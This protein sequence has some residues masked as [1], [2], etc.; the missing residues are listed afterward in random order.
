MPRRRRRRGRCHGGG[1]R[2][3][4]GVERSLA[5]AGGRA[6]DDRL[7]LAPAQRHRPAGDRRPGPGRRAASAL[8]DAR[9]LPRSHACA[10]RC[11]IRRICATWTARPS[12]SPTRSIGGE[13]IARV[14]RLRRRRRHLD[15]AAGPLSRAR[16]GAEPRVHMPD[17]I[18]EGYGPNAPGAGAAAR[19]AAP[20]WWSRS[21]AAPPPST[22]WTRAAD[23]GL[24]VI[25]VDHH[26]AEPRLPHGVRGGQPEP[27]ATR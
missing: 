22:R 10:A 11:P 4:V 3:A 20:G 2:R 19:P 26:T 23:A 6:D 21:I 14:R 8:D 12:A 25:V 13:R 16:S 9:R 7:A 5:R 1:E 15:G 17:R 18:A 24:D 27:A